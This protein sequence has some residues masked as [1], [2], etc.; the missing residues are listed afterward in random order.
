MNR[1]LEDAVKQL[2]NGLYICELPT[3]YGKTYSVAKLI[4][5]MAED[6]NEKRKIIYL[7]TLT[8]NLP[9][10][11]LKKIY[12]ND[13][14]GYKKDVLRIRS[15]YDEV[16]DTLPELEVP[17]KYQVESYRELKTLISNYKS[18]KEF[19]I[20]DLHYLDSLNERINENEKKFRRYIQVCLK[21]KFR[22][23]SDRLKAIHNNPEYQWIGKLYPA[24]FT[25]E[26]QVLLM[27]V[28]KFLSKNT[29]IVEPSYNFLK[30]SF[31][32]TQLFL[33]MNS[34]PRKKLSRKRL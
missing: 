32:K 8:K 5:A 26:H 21:E 1:Y 6:P 33:S 27:T 2:E 25:D 7:T 10:K 31:L 24:V 14:D 12:G 13:E 28:K 15:N 3:G 22:N 19:V 34:M 30:S 16:F 20:K 29:T 11:T 17:E 18:A 4:K 23:K 9:D